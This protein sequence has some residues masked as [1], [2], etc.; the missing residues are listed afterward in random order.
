MKHN[1]NIKRYIIYTY[2]L[3]WL[4]ISVLAG[5]YVVSGKN[6]WVFEL[7]SAICSWTPT[8]V[9]IILFKKI[10]PD[11]KIKDFYRK[12]FGNR[13][14]IS[15]IITVTLIQA[16]VLFLSTYLFSLSNRIKYSALWDFS[17]YTLLTGF[18][19]TLIQGATGEESGWRGYLQNV[20]EK[21][22]GVIKASLIVGVVWS[23][24]HTPLWF[25]SGMKGADLLIYIITFIIGNISLSVI[26]GTCY[27][28]CKNL[29]VPIWIHFIFNFLARPYLGQEVNVRIWL[30]LFYA[31]T[32][33]GFSLWYIFISKKKSDSA[34]NY[35][36]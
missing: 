35:F 34:E 17:A 16:V 31:V 3:F 15:L 20:Y 9:L 24:W 33:V 18:L 12:L 23:F 32:A 6:K 36:K 27:S 13:I 4:S 10:F 11:I 8:I 30:A 19:F 26:I 29:F 28:Y 21:K 5:I 1:K 2:L 22:H 7:G 25:A 14:N